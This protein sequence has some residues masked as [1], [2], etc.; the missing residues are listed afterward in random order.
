MD[1]T[2]LVTGAKG[3]LGSAVVDRLERLGMEVIGT[4]LPEVDLTDRDAVAGIIERVQ[5]NHVIH[6]AA[7]TAV[8][9][10][11]SDAD[12]CRAANILAPTLVAK[13]CAKTGASMLLVS[14]DFVFDGHSRTP[15]RETDSPNPQGIYACS[16]LAGERSLALALERHQIV[17]TAWLFGPN[18]KNF[19]RSRF[20]NLTSGMHL[21]VVDD[22][23]GCP[24][25][26][27]DL[28]E[29]LVSLSQHDAT[30]VFHL[31]NKG[32]CTWYELTCKI[33]ELAG[34]DP[35]CVKPIP[36]E[37]YPCPAERPAWSVLDCSKAYALGVEPMRHWNEALENYV[38]GLSC[39]G[40]S[41]EAKTA[42]APKE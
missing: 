23:T 20:E 37:E 18:G 32:L 29:R 13:A 38:R 36:T 39:R 10:A 4:D 19:V 14:T 34:F 12:T 25:Y 11:E 26:T 27:L 5:P 16:K 42:S 17:R 24:T 2:Y 22:Q 15:Y 8:D 9:G 33:A 1:E 6:C 7:Y 41:S 3:M 31:V 28:A 30:G 40:E 35:G 21:S